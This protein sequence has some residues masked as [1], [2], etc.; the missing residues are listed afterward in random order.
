LTPEQI[1]NV[2]GIIT[3]A[4]GKKFVISNL[5]Y[6]KNRYEN[7]SVDAEWLDDEE[8]ALLRQG[9]I[10]SDAIHELFMQKA[11]QPLRY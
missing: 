5:P 8:K 9:I 3:I 2:D 7:V 10:P 1:G 11:D 6:F 4:D